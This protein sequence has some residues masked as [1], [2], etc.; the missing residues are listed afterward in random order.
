MQMAA[1]LMRQLGVDM[2]SSQKVIDLTVN[3]IRGS[4]KK[5]NL[6]DLN[7]LAKNYLQ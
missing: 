2:M 6:D 4:V 3:E 1:F 7:D 5:A